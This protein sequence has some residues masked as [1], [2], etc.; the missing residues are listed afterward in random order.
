MAVLEGV[1][2]A[3]STQIAQFSISDTGSLVYVPGLLWLHVVVA[4]GAFET[5]AHA[6]PWSQ[7][8]AWGLTP[9]LVGD[10]IKLGLAALLLPAAW[11]LVGRARR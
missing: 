4:G 2:R 11:R 9:Y 3:L 10:A 7:T 5:A 8:L 6:T 1:R